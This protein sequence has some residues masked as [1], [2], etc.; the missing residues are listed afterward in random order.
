[1]A[2]AFLV[3]LLLGLSYFLLAKRLFDYF[4]LSFFSKRVNF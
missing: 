1:M 2:I 3:I 4:T